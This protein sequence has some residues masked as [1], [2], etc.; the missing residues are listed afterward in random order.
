[1]LFNDFC[2]AGGIPPAEVTAT[3]GNQK[4]PALLQYKQVCVRGGAERAGFAL[5]CTCKEHVKGGAVV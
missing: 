2:V 3:Y 1:M 5:S 4:L